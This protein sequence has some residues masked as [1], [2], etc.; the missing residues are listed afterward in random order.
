MSEPQSITLPELTDPP[1]GPTAVIHPPSWLDPLQLE[2]YFDMSRPLEVDVGAGKGR[3]LLAHA[4]KHPERNFLG[5]ERQL[6]RI[7]K[8]DRK[9]V[10]QGLKNVRLIRIEASYALEHLLPPQ[11]VAALY[12]YFLDPWPKRRHHRRRLFNPALLNVIDRTLKPGGTIH[13][14]TDHLDYFAEI[15]KLFAA[16]ARFERIEAPEPPD[17]ERTDFELL[18]MSQGLPIGRCAFRKR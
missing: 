11:G 12:F 13:A 17:D 16:D 3:F 15:V 5:I 14:A 8:M 10:Q 18:W 7:R 1:A 2:D 6:I 4:A 9:I